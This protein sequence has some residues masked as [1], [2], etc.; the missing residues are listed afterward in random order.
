MNTA[1][2]WDHYHYIYTTLR[3]FAIPTFVAWYILD[4]ISSD[5]LTDS[6]ILQCR[7]RRSAFDV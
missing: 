4:K 3:T 1:S 5:I 6:C 7:T 2:T